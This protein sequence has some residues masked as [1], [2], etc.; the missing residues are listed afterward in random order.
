MQRCGPNC[1]RKGAALDAALHELDEA[2]R[3]RKIDTRLDNDKPM[4]RSG[5]VRLMFAKAARVIGH[6]LEVICDRAAGMHASTGCCFHGLASCKDGSLQ[7][8]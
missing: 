8:P 7:G 6:T 5:A 4:V 2:Y 1:I 3:V